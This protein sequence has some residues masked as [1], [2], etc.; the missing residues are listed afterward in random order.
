[1]FMVCFFSSSESVIFLFSMLGNIFFKYSCFLV[2]LCDLHH[3]CSS[4]HM[5][6]CVSFLHHPKMAEHLPVFSLCFPFLFSSDLLL[7]LHLE[8]SFSLE[9]YLLL[10]LLLSSVEMVYSHVVVVGSNLLF[11]HLILDHSLLLL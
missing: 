8:V 10:L 5:R 7:D 4:L 11:L 2:L 6:M 9:S 1:M 3:P